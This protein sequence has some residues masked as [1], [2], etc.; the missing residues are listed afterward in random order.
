MDVVSGARERG[1]FILR[2]VLGFGFLYAG[3]EKLL[4]FA[5]E[6]KPWSA[7]GFLKFATGGTIPNMVGHTDPMSH[8]PTQAIWTGLAGD[9]TLL[10]IVNFLVVF[11]ELAIGIALIFGIAT[12]LA[13][14]LGAVMMF[15]FWIAAWDFQYGIVN[16]QFVYMILSA[17]LAYASAGR[18]VG[19][20][21]ILEKTELA[22]RTPVLRYVIG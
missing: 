14:I 10:G 11:G 19:L 7:F 9:P 13:G 22:H 6:D 16:Q 2:V 3:I 8:N 17:F 1:L 4:N 20:D 12:R 18:V 5:G 15:F 21:G